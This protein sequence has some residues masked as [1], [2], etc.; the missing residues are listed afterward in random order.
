MEHC[1]VEFLFFLPPSILFHSHCLVLLDSKTPQKV[2][3]NVI[4]IFNF[5]TTL[6]L[7]L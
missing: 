7:L 4:N 6:F 2:I 1:S 3:F 5:F